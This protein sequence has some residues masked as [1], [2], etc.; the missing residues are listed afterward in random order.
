M[1]FHPDPGD[2][3]ICHE[4]GR[5]LTRKVGQSLPPTFSMPPPSARSISSD[6]RRR[7][8]ERC[9]SYLTLRWLFKKCKVAKK[10]WNRRLFE[11]GPLGF[12]ANRSSLPVGELLLGDLSET[13]VVVGNAPHDRPGF[14]VCHLIGNRAS[15][16]C[17]EAPML[18][19]PETNFLHRITSHQLVGEM[20]RRF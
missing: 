20:F 16:L 15:F 4:L 9:V 6:F 17:T 5:Y 3:C 1:D 14:L 11:A 18:R 7:I 8:W 13:V 12:V 19:V 10:P 2:C